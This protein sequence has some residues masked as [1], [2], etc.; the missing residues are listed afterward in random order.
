MFSITT[1]QCSQKMTKKFKK[2]GK[3]LARERR[4]DLDRYAEKIRDIA[5]D[6]RRRTKELLKDHREFFEK[7]PSTK[8]RTTAIDFFEK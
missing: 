4:A 1:T 2:F 6:E 3:R 8:N 5:A 7:S